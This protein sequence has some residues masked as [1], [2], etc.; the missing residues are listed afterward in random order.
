MLEVRP[1]IPEGKWDWFLLDKV[2]Y[3]GKLLTIRWDK[4]GNRYGKGK[5]LVVFADGKEVHRS[6]KLKAF[7]AGL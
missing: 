6:K 3:H 4:D 7:E 2:P 5:G 1:L